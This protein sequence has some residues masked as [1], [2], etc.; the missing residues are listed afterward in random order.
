MVCPV[1]GS[2]S[3]TLEAKHVRHLFLLTKLTEALGHLTWDRRFVRL[4]RDQFAA[5]GG[6][7]GY[8]EGIQRGTMQMAFIE[9]NVVQ[10]SHSAS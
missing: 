9:C 2:G 7:P 3:R 4:E 8:S 6:P 5:A 10:S 1:I